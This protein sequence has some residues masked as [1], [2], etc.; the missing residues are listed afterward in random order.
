MHMHVHDHV[1]ICICILA[2]PRELCICMD[3]HMYGYGYVSAQRGISSPK[4]IHMQIHVHPCISVH[5][6]ICVH[7]YICI[8][9]QAAASAMQRV[10]ELRVANRS[11]WPHGVAFANQRGLTRGVVKI[12][13]SWEAKYVWFWTGEDPPLLR[14]CACVHVYT[15]AHTHACTC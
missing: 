14:M 10:E 15:C 1:C 6:S 11:V 9:I 5:P 8:Y 13:W 7:I 2:D 12:G 3:M 4:L